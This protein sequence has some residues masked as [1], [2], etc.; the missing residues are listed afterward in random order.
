[1]LLE[2]MRMMSK[3]ALFQKVELRGLRTE[4]IRELT[5][6]IIKEPSEQ[7]LE[8]VVKESEGNPLYAVESATFLINSD[9]IEKENSIWKLKDSQQALKMPPDHS[10]P[11]C[12]KAKQAGQIGG[13]DNRVRFSDR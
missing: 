11:Y 4:A 10:G 13:A 2:T 9:A 1:M 7:V 3:E 5:T 6:M 8:L 12:Q